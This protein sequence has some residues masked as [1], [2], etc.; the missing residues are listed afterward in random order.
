MH[1]RRGSL[2]ALL[3][4]ILLLGS[5][6]GTKGQE[7]WDVT[8]PRGETREIDFTTSEG[9]W[10]SL[11]VDPTG[12][13]L[14][15]DLLG[16]V[17][18]TPVEGGQAESLTQDSGIAVNFD[19]RISPDGRTIAFVSDRTGQ[20][21]LWLMNADGS[22]PRPV[23]EDGSVRV[24]Q[25]H[26]TPDGQYIVV[27]RQPG[28]L[29]M[30][31]RDGGTG[32]A[33]LGEELEASAWPSVSA[34]GRHVYF[35]ITKARTL[36][37]S[38]GGDVQLR[39][40]EL[41]SGEVIKITGGMANTQIR[42]SSG[43]GFAPEISPDGR[44]LAF[45]RK[46]PNGTL[47]Y[48]GHSFG[49]RT[50]LWIRDLRTGAERVVM[51][52]IEYDHSDGG[53]GGVLPGYAW[54]PDGESI[55]ITQGGGIRRVD[56]TGG[57]V[58]TIPFAARVH[59]VISERAYQPFSI[60]DDPF[61]ARFLRWHTASPDGQRL[62]FQAVG[63]VWVMELPNGT[64]RRV[65]PS[66]FGPFEYSPAWSPDGS[67]LVFTSADDRARGHLWS[68]SSSGGEPR[69]LTE[70]DGE[71]L[72]PVFAP[73]GQDVLVVRGSGVTNHGRGWMFNPFYDLVLV[74]ADGGPARA[75]T[76][77][78]PPSE[79]G[80][81][82]VSRRSIVQP[83]WGP[84]GR[85]YF[86]EDQERGDGSPLV[87]LVSVGSDGSGERV[88][89]TFPY[90]D[91]IAPSPDGRW[92]AFQEGD[93][94]YLTPFPEA[95]TGD[96][97]PHVDKAAGTFPVTQV[98]RTGGMFLRWRDAGTLEYGTGPVHVVYEVEAGQ[99][100]STEAQLTVPRRIPPGQVAFTD[101]R[102]IALAEGREVIERGTLVVSGSRITCVG[103]CATEG[104][105]RV[106]DAEGITLMPGLVDM[107]AHHHR[108][109]R[110]VFGT[111]NHETAVYLAYGVTT[112]MDNSMWHQNVQT[113]AELIRAGALP[114]PRTYSTGPPLYN[115]DG[116]R[117]NDLSSY[118]VTL[119]NVDRLQSWGAVSLKQYMQPRRQQRQWV[120]EAA[121]A[122]GLMVTAEGGDLEYNLS[123]IMDG[124]TGW[125]HPL[126]YLPLYSDVTRF[127]G[128]AETVYSVTFGVGMGPWN[129]DYFWAESD[130][131]DDEKLLR[132]MPWRS[133]LPHARRRELRPETDY[134]YRVL[135]EG[136]KD[137]IE[138]GGHGAIGAH[139]QAHGIAPHWEVWMAASAMGPLRAIEL[140]T[141]EGAYFLGALDDLGT[142]EVGKLADL[143]VLGS[144]PLEDIRSTTDIRYVMQGGVL[145]DADTLDEIWP[146][147]RAYGAYPWVDDAAIRNDE[148]PVDVWRG[149]E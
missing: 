36:Q 72:N 149:G 103:E 132:W 77:V 144:N 121:R 46:I 64:P 28:G 119:D 61:R 18:R 109:T 66:S 4:L 44:Y 125:E 19:P 68:V 118:E 24:S 92:V 147:A 135:A 89:L 38:V 50:A 133:F 123:M 52:P 26:W 120:S 58:S 20:Y 13:W 42:L 111:K 2:V 17:H 76:R 90:A 146:E 51:D 37:G 99:S 117:Q 73:D 49:P 70:E 15:F 47:S 69:R 81:Y 85:I 94:V 9:T 96:E 100:E 104:V 112:S 39:R 41:T 54:A 110:G 124:H 75:V 122:R 136:V 14:V 82:G 43:G 71:Y 143:L 126:G 129:Q 62:A 138:A 108:E 3:T 145:Y 140:G 55:F 141:K 45:G 30:Y 48:R 84:E 131:Y 87:A 67:T 5:A 1:D 22:N 16:H 137:V 34:D 74:P 105:D 32:V 97:P 33:L 78:N 56:V 107:H 88:H 102:I 65:T 6:G 27:R 148:V 57:A 101:A 142:L 114:G 7:A 10:M 86:A 116:F 95:G 25:P 115:G 40:L 91:E 11:D 31:H 53:D 93:N 128:Q 106:I 8:E 113:V 23:F 130:Y 83:A 127:F 21:N 29:W 134:T 80:V 35:Q 139:G 59:R 98:S 63:R 60:T 79:V 12:T